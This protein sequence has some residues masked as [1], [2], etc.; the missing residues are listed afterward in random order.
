M[1]DPLAR[2]FEIALDA[3]EK[4]TGTDLRTE[5]PTTTPAESPE[6]TP[7]EEQRKTERRETASRPK[8]SSSAY[9]K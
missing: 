7:R 2:A 4:K 1:S 3:Y 6:K 5:K 9:R 8:V